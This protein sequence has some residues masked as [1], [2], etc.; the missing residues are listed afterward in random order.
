MNPSQINI[1]NTIV[2]F[3][4]RFQPFHKGHNDTYRYLKSVFPNVFITTTNTKSK[5]EAQRY[6]FNFEEKINI[7]NKLAEVDVIDI[8]PEPVRYPYSDSETL[9]YI[10]RMKY[11]EDLDIKTKFENIDLNEAIIIFVISKKDS[12]RFKF[13]KEGLSL[14]KNQ[15]P[16]KIQKL[17]FLN[18]RNNNNNYYPI[19]NNIN[20]QKINNTYNY[21]LTMPTF[22]FEILG[23]PIQGATQFREMMKNPP[24]GFTSNDVVNSL[25]NKLPENITREQSEML[26]MIKERLT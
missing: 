20:I 18:N 1:N 15:T 17:R 10:K 22:N 9:S 3:P 8:V 6:P 26:N 2:I 16:A 24:K 25:Y 19:Y 5:K 23:F 7:M 14:K 21:I 4:G 11:S 13:P 12:E